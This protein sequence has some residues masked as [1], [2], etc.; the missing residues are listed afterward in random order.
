MVKEMPTPDL[1]KVN[2]EIAAMFP[3]RDMTTFKPVEPQY[4]INADKSLTYLNK[5]QLLAQAA[6]SPAWLANKNSSPGSLPGSSFLLQ[7]NSPIAYN[8]GSSSTYSLYSPYTDTT[9]TTDSSGN[10]FMSWVQSVPPMYWVGGAILAVVLL[11]K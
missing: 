6:V 2:Q 8:G 5:D 3:G 10:S 7:N 11:R 1:N 4:V 9:T